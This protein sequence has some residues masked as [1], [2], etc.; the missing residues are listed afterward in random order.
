[1]KIHEITITNIA[2]LKGS[3]HIDFDQ[4]AK[5]SNLFAITGPTGSGKSTILNCLSLALYGEVYK[6]GSS[7]TDFVTM[8]EEYGEIEL[9]FS[10]A[11]QTYLSHWKLKIRKTNGDFYKKPQL[12]R[13]L[14]LLTGT[15]KEAIDKSPEEIIGL[16]FNQ[17]CK[18]SILN[19]GEFAKFL[20][21]SFIERKDILEKFYDGDNISQLNLILKEKINKLL[22]EKENYKNQVIGINQAMDEVEI[23]EESIAIMAKNYENKNSVLENLASLS[24]MIRELHNKNNSIEQLESSQKK[25]KNDITEK[26]ERLNQLTIKSKQSSEEASKAKSLYSQNKEMLSEAIKKFDRKV[27]LEKQKANLDADLKNLKIELES[28][29]SILD[30]LTEQRTEKQNQ[31]SECEKTNPLLKKFSAFEFSD[32]EYKVKNLSSQLN[33]NRE[34]TEK[35]NALLEKLTGEKNELNNQIKTLEKKWST[36]N[37]NT[38]VLNQK[39]LLQKKE[40]L[41]RLK[42]VVV[43]G[44]D[45]LQEGEQSLYRVST[46]ITELEKKI[47]DLTEKERILELDIISLDKR[48]ET[49]KN[50]ILISDLYV[51]SKDKGVCFV[52]NRDMSDIEIDHKKDISLEDWLNQEKIKK[53]QLRKNQEEMADLKLQLLSFQREKQSLSQRQQKNLN[54]LRQNWNQNSDL[55]LLQDQIKKD[56]IDLLKTRITEL[57]AQRETLDNRIIEFNRDEQRLKDYQTRTETLSES[58]KNTNSEIAKLSQDKQQ[59]V[60]QKSE[61]KEAL[62]LNR[63]ISEMISQ[64]TE[65]AKAGKNLD[66]LK[67][68]IEKLKIELKA[69]EETF[70]NIKKQLSV[71]KQD[72][73]INRDEL[74]SVENFL[75]E[76]K[77]DFNP[78]D[79]LKRLEQDTESTQEIFQRDNEQLKQIQVQYAEINSRYETLQETLKALLAEAAELKEKIRSFS[80]EVAKESKKDLDLFFEILEKLAVTQISDKQGLE[81]FLETKLIFEKNLDEFKGQVE[82]LKKELTRNQILLKQKKENE[83]KIEEIQ[84]K[85]SDLQEIENQYEAL[86]LLIGKDEF[87]NFVLGKIE[88]LLLQQTN[89]ELDQLCQGRYRLTQT[90]KKNRLLTE[91]LVIDHFYGAQKRK[92]TTLSGGET[93]M[94]SL[95]LA[96]AL[97]EMTRGKTQIDSLFIDEGFGTLDQDAIEDV[98]DLLIDMQNS[99]KQIGL[100]SH[101]KKLTQRIAVNINLIK[102]ES[103]LS[104]IE[105]VMN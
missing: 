91:F 1:M 8:G 22:Q 101:V 81:I 68:E 28:R 38:E 3:H 32:Y 23:T 50:H 42:D 59:F 4:V 103:G 34:L 26:H 53:D 20:K 5:A 29:E 79:R 69:N 18:T 10:H 72:F 7:S 78:A 99:G 6:K 31:E 98:L 46:K 105:L 84:K 64:L 70:Q 86:N 67:K 11:Q 65:L 12:T 17:F 77:I 96:L 66:N 54:T 52:C 75:K 80:V 21:S 95:A 37:L 56:H 41:Q 85:I 93:F 51:G 60:S 39:N 45:D 74:S 76:K 27:V 35:S 33:T 61:I 44:L 94:V 87:R 102:S 62:N 100:I 25:L 90:H 104:D 97:A 49:E 43:S 82:E 57:A 71:K 24:Q 58:I 9:I 36:F 14:F 48:I 2:S 16:N 13:T 47:K 63:P 92:I 55:P 40:R 19:Q 83:R 15:S 73:N 88:S 30:K 89:K